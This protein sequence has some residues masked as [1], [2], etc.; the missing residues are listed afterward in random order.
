MPENFIKEGWLNVYAPASSS[1]SKQ[2][3]VLKNDRIVHYKDE[4]MER[5]LL[6]VL[7]IDVKEIMLDPKD[8]LITCIVSKSFHKMKAKNDE[9]RDSWMDNLTKTWNNIMKNATAIR[10]KQEDAALL[11]QKTWKGHMTRRHWVPIITTHMARWKA[12]VTIQRAYRR[13]LK[14]KRNAHFIDSEGK[15]RKKF[16]LMDLVNAVKNHKQKLQVIDYVMVFENYDKMSSSS[17]SSSSVKKKASSKGNGNSEGDGTEKK[18]VEQKLLIKQR[19]PQNKKEEE[20][21]KKQLKKTSIEDDDDIVEDEFM[22]KGRKR[23]PKKKQAPKRVKYVVNEA[24]A[25]EE[26]VA[27]QLEQNMVYGDWAD[28]EEAEDEEDETGGGCFA[29]RL[30]SRPVEEKIKVKELIFQKMKEREIIFEERLSKDE[31]K[32]IV[33]ISATF[34]ALCAQA[35][36]KGFKKLLKPE[37]VEVEGCDMVEFVDHQR[38]RYQGIEDQDSFFFPSERKKLVHDIMTDIEV[39]QHEKL[40]KLRYGDYL[41][42]RALEMKYIVALYPVHEKEVMAA[43]RKSW[44]KSARFPPTEMIAR[45]FG[46][47][48]ALFFCFT[49]FYSKWMFGLAVIGIIAFVIQMIDKTGQIEALA[50]TIFSF[51]VCVWSA[52]FTKHWKRLESKKTYEWNTFNFKESEKIR[53]SFEGTIQHSPITGKNERFY[54]SRLRMMKYFVTLPLSALMLL[55]AVAIILLLTIYES[56]MLAYFRSLSN[57]PFVVFILELVPSI[58]NAIVSILFSYI[59]QFMAVSMNKWENYRTQS[60]YDNFFVYRIVFFRLLNT[61][62]SL[63]F[64]TFGFNPFSDDPGRQRYTSLRTRLI[65]MFAIYFVKTQASQTLLPMALWVLSSMSRWMKKRSYKKKKAI[66]T[67]LERE[68]QM[69]KESAEKSKKAKKGKK[70]KS[71]S[72]SSSSSSA[73]GKKTKKPTARLI[74]PKQ[75]EKL[76]RCKADLA[77]EEKKMA[78]MPTSMEQ[79]MGMKIYST[80]EPYQDLAMQFGYTTLFSPAF[81][82]APLISFIGNQLALRAEAIKLCFV[83]QRPI[84]MSAA[85][86]GSFMNV[87]EILSWLS[88]LTNIGMIFFHFREEIWAVL[89]KDTPLTEM[90]MMIQIIIFFAIENVFLLVKGLITILIPNITNNVKNAMKKDEYARRDILA[91]LKARE[92]ENRLKEQYCAELAN[93]RSKEEEKRKAKV[94]ELKNQLEKKDS[95]S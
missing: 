38:N 2:W 10:K 44:L 21:K 42:P 69:A 1:S 39:M 12:A 86:I 92:R 87:L 49:G 70:K 61:Y 57:V 50:G 89:M 4:K 22:A 64:L 26:G 67:Q 51:I 73:A 85:N 17:S 62:F 82:I 56:D 27:D 23:K 65:T 79:E 14:R 29:S 75:V 80:F 45:Y 94:I 34:E 3:T 20:K 72:S 74:S 37:C 25:A 83:C 55:A 24:S 52:L 31:K 63:F 6:T 53:P 76:R 77:A 90:M 54:P 9:E 60:D 35:E 46:E 8:G 58:L 16:E 48:I 43:L 68:I 7:L 13:Y 33:Y 36:V 93:F 5:P 71:S 47:K 81:P 32:T 30:I 84:P 41:I 88:V 28:L 40:G 15:M 95:D 18:H 11:I 91:N 19:T 78:K 59:Y 66:V